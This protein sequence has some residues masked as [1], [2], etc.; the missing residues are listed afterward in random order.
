[1]PSQKPVVKRY[2]PGDAELDLADLLSLNEAL[3]RLRELD[4]R[5]AQVVELR[6]FGGLTEREAADVLVDAT[7]RPFMLEINP[8]CGVFYAPSDPGSAGPQ[9]QSRRVPA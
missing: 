6:F 8:N 7:G 3:D 9:S 2:K 4:E 1:M 5:Q